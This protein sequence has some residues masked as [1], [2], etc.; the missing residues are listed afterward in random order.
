ML[1][2]DYITFITLFWETG[3]YIIY[4]YLLL[5]GRDICLSKLILG[6]LYENLNQV[7]TSIKEYQSGSSFIIPGPIRLF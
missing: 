2:S 7:V 1:N 3:C 4:V 6:S 5:K